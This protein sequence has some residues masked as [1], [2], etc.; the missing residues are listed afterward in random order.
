MHPYCHAAA[1]AALSTLAATAAQALTIDSFDGPDRPVAYWSA[2]EPGSATLRT[3]M[4]GAVPGGV[5]TT[6]IGPNAAL[7][8]WQASSLSGAGQFW[9]FAYSGQALNTTLGYGLQAPL[10]LDLSREAEFTVD[11]AWGIAAKLT[12]YAWSHAADP[13]LNPF[14]SAFSIDVP[15]S[16]DPYTLRLPM[17]AFAAD[18]N[19]PGPVDWANVDGLAFAFSADRGNLG[20][21]FALDGIGTAAAVPEPGAAL[22]LALGL[23][24][25]GWRQRQARAFVH[26]LRAQAFARRSANLSFGPAC[27][28]WR[29][30]DGHRWNV[31]KQ[32][33]NVRHRQRDA[34]G[35]AICATSGRRATAA[36][37]LDRGSGPVRKGS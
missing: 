25:L 11:V 18:P 31:G 37:S 28:P 8:G 3:A 22:L 27:D 4:A 10:D 5:R 20:H 16:R 9:A 32:T 15:E 35:A 36:I 21:Y 23:A 13:S 1:A 30:F 17:A 2:L 33:L 14:T 29:T 24:G 6:D 12:V 34:A 26:S 7:G 19:A